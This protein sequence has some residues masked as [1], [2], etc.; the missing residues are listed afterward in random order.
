PKHPFVN[1]PNQP[2]PALPALKFLPPAKF[3]ISIFSL[4]YNRPNIQAL[5]SPS[6][7]TSLLVRH[8]GL[9]LLAAIPSSFVS[10][11]QPIPSHIQ[12]LSS[13]FSKED[14][15]R[16]LEQRATRQEARAKSYRPFCQLR[17]TFLLRIKG[18]HKSSAVSKTLRKRWVAALKL[19]VKYITYLHKHPSSLSMSPS[20]TPIEGQ[21]EPRASCSNQQEEHKGKGLI[22]LDPSQEGW[23]ELFG[24]IQIGYAVDHHD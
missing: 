17:L 11:V 7:P 15:E 2:S 22:R 12:T 9:F 14:Q 18:H 19:I 16:W 21:E 4:S 20:L 3:T 23:H 13:C 8:T 24:N 5:L 1:R 6:L 10:L